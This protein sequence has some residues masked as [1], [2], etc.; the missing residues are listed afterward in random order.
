MHVLYV[1]VNAWHLN[2]T[3]NLLPILVKQQFTRVA[4]YGPGYVDEED[5]KLGLLRFIDREGP[6]DA[7]IFGYGGLSIFHK[8]ADQDFRTAKSFYKHSAGRSSLESLAY[9][10]ADVR[11]HC[12]HVP[13]A[14]RLLSTLNF[15]YYAATQAQVDILIE[16]SISL[17]G[18]NEQFVIALE[19]LP[20]YAKREKHYVR[21][22]GCFSNAWRDFLIKHPE[23]VVTALHFVSPSEYCFD[24]LALRPYETAIPG[25]EY[26]LRKQAMRQLEKSNYRVSSKA[27]FN[28]Y[29]LANYTGLPVF[30]NPVLARLYNLSFQRSLADTQCVYTARGGFGIP[31][32]KFFE[33]PAAGG[34]LVCSSPN[35]FSN[36]GFVNKKHYI[37]AEP[38]QLLDVLSEWLDNEEAQSVARQGQDLVIAKHSLSAR[39]SQIG[40]CMQAMLEGKYHG[41]RWQAGE[42]VLQ[43][44]EGN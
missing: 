33:I 25:V 31:I 44:K 11:N 12:G 37:E 32:R 10:F 21:K 20:N 39:G 40:I 17:I 9:F 4:F 15:D 43:L 16:K 6:F 35:G 36:I 8:D 24:A 26:L 22:Q 30:S 41:A 14:I 34:L 23:K 2:P 19:D 27:Y 28:L 1:D 7:V 3:A 42:F 13:T 29:R 5:I 38:D 18:P